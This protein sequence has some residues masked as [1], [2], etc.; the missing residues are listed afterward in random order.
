MGLGAARRA[1]L[2][3]GERNL[4]YAVPAQAAADQRVGGAMNVSPYS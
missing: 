4:Q 1:E 3:P 2:L